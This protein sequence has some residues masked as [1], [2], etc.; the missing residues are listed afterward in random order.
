[1]TERHILSGDD[2]SMDC[3]GE[4]LSRVLGGVASERDF[5]AFGAHVE[6]CES[7]RLSRDVTL[8]FERIGAASDDS[9]TLARIT[10]KVMASR[11]ASRA[12]PLRSVSRRPALRISLAALA[13]CGAA[14]AGTWAVPLIGERLR[15]SEPSA[16]VSSASQGD[17]SAKSGSTRGVPP[18]AADGLGREPPSSLVKGATPDSRE[19]SPAAPDEGASPAESRRAVAS[20]RLPSEAITPATLFKEANQARRRGDRATA[21]KHYQALQQRFSGSK[22]AA[23]SQVSLGGLLLESGATVAA[24]AQFDRYLSSASHGSLRAEALYGRGRALGA[25][26][27][28]NDE[29]KN[30]QRLLNTFPESPYS[31]EARSRLDQ[32]R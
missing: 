18:S 17:P 29:I 12:V 4:L 27:R 1:M 11:K 3:K 10:E 21:I 24:L 23:L 20:S 22:E 9:A 19:L 31:G 32:L 2:K 7:C 25:L 26:G 6:T 8:D 15:E 13:F 14:A 5:L 28:T 16:A 30:W